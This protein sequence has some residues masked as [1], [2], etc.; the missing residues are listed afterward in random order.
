MKVEQLVAFK[1]IQ[2]R[3]DGIF[4]ELSQEA[5]TSI[6]LVFFF[7]GLALS[8]EYQPIAGSRGCVERFW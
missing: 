6:Q 8:F 4:R 2:G 7:A 1:V 3:F 5:I